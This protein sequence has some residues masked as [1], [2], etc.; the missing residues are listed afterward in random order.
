MIMNKK[1]C[2]LLAAVVLAAGVLS[3]CGESKG[4]PGDNT[5]EAAQ[6]GTAAA[7]ENKAVT[8]YYLETQP[9]EAKTALTKKMLEAF[10]AQNA[11]ATVEFQSTPNDQ[12]REKLLTLAAGGK[13]PDIIEIND[14]WLA[15]LASSNNLE[16]LNPHIEKWD[17]K[18]NIV[19]AAYKLGR[20]IEDKLYYIPYGLYGTAVYYN[21]AMLEATGNK[22]PETTAEFYEAAKA[23]TDESAGKYGYSFRGGLYGPT[24]AV[25]WM[26]GEIGSPDIFDANGKCVFDTPEAIEGLTKYAA[27]YKDKVS[28][29]D[30]TSWAFRECVDGFTSGVTGLLI[31]SNE[32]VQICNEKMGEGKFD[33]VHLPLGSS[34]KA[35][36]TSGQTGYAMSA[37]SENKE[38][39]WKLLSYLLSA[40]GSKEFSISMGFTPV[41]KKL[42]DDPT[43]NN[44]P[45]KVY[46]EQVMSEN[47]EFSNNPSYLPEWGEF[48][49]AWGTAECQKMIL[50]QQTA[51]QTAKN[52]ADFLNKAK[53]KYDAEN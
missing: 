34:G 7:G 27:L 46:L 21:K 50:G 22:A 39:A 41:N 9:T 29:P 43:F 18:D 36:D 11:G 37:K 20:V 51:E 48:C 35:F 32:V 52:F 3:A 44:G 4:R 12:A 8:I 19:D 15:P 5:G 26:L 23:M 40:E 14:S 25:M 42:T 45:I 10:K 31:Q 16:D 33:T 13:L 28:P 17:E 53:E 30:S 38:V 2:A 6:T 47:I 49:G 1:I 24:H